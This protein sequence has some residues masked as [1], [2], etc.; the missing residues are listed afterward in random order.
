LETTV[1]YAYYGTDSQRQ[2]DLES[3]ERVGNRKQS[4]TLRYRLALD[5]RGEIVGGRALSS[6]GHFL[7]IP[8]Y[9]VQATEDGSKPGNPYV[10]AKKVIALARASAVPE[11]QRK[12]DGAT[13]G[14]R[15]D[16]E[17]E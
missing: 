5:K 9:P 11:V 17:S 13:I 1:T 14:P 10:D 7:W 3:G 6:G 4:M 2:T 15:V 8:L 16:P 12:F